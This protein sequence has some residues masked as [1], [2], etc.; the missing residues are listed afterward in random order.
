MAV[1]K[2]RTSP[3]KTKM[4]RAHDALGK[5]T[6]VK[7]SNCGNPVQIHRVCPSCGFY[8]GQQVTKAAD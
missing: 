2:K 6:P 3:M 7:C 8:R 1:P 4:R 5:A